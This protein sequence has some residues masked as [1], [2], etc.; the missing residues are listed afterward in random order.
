MERTLGIKYVVLNVLGKIF[1]SQPNSKVVDDISLEDAAL[2]S[3]DSNLDR[4]VKD[5]EKR[6]LNI[7]QPL[8]PEKENIREQIASEKTKSPSKSKSKVSHI[9]VQEVDIDRDDK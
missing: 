1:G 2:L 9:D 6:N 8:T 5:Y 4:I 3:S 7:I